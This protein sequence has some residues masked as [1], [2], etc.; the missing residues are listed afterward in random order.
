[1][2][3]YVVPLTN[4]TLWIREGSS[5]D[6]APMNGVIRATYGVSQQLI[7]NIA[8]GDQWL[9]DWIEPM[10]MV[11]NN[12]AAITLT[13]LKKQHLTFGMVGAAMQVSY[14]SVARGDISVGLLLLMLAT[15]L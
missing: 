10:T 3:Q 14:L 15:R 7:K 6:P 13:S 11:P 8:G 1:M 12:G 5:L 2:V 4:T 9:P